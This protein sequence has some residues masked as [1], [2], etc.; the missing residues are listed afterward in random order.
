MLYAINAL[1]KLFQ[2]NS[3]NRPFAD[4]EAEKDMPVDG[5]LYA[6]SF[7]RN[8]KGYDREIGHQNIVR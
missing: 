5:R 8:M 1:K 4:V 2:S 3:C 6:A 7:A